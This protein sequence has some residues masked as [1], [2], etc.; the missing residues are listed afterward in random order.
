ITGVEVDHSDVSGAVAG[1]ADLFVAGR[2]IAEG[3]TID[4]PMVVLD[5]VIDI[6]ELRSKVGDAMGQFGAS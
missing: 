2:D 1:A 3:L 6:E 4:A 5:S